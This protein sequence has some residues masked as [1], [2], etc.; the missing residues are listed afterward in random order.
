MSALYNEAKGKLSEH[1]GSPL[2]LSNVGTPFLPVLGS[3][4]VFLKTLLFLTKNLCV[5]DENHGDAVCPISDERD[6]IP[7]SWLA[8]DVKVRSGKE[9]RVVEIS[10]DVKFKKDDDARLKRET[11]QS[12][13]NRDKFQEL[14][15]DERKKSS[16]TLQISVYLGR[17]TGERTRPRI[18]PQSSSRALRGMS[19]SVLGPTICSYRLFESIGL[20]YRPVIHL[21]SSPVDFLNSRL[22]CPVFEV[23]V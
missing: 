4:A 21:H 20:F 6:K 5:V 8:M 18:Q 9:R 19:Y 15:A 13:P 17:S 2:S 14:E 1:T 11:M 7:R 12:Q 3:L 22:Y 10:Y 16:H 23:H